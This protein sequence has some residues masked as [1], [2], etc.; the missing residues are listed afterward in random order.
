MSTATKT[1]LIATPSKSHV[2]TKY[3]QC[4]LLVL[5]L[6]EAQTGYKVNHRFLCGKSNLDQAR[7]MMLTDWYNKAQEDD[8][9]LFIDSDHIFDITDIKRV[10]NIG[11]DVA[12]GIYPN[13]L[14]RT[15]SYL[16]NPT[17][18]VNGEDNRLLYGATGFMLI[19]KPIL[20]KV[21]KLLELEIGR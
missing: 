15:T 5:P 6:I 21:A 10:V 7:S 9:F 20:K 17:D 18:F 1:L 12:C 11:G 2:N 4:I 16:L 3:V 14:G 13:S 19:R 8:L